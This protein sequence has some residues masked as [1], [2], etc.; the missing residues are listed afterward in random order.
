MPSHEEIDN[1][2]FLHCNVKSQAPVMSSGIKI[3]LNGNE[4]FYSCKSLHSLK[5]IVLEKLSNFRMPSRHYCLKV[6]RLHC[7]N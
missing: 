2:Y 5:S 1:S 4:R 7:W 3:N 6:N